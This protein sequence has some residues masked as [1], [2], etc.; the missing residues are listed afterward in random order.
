MSCFVHSKAHRVR[1]SAPHHDGANRSKLRIGAGRHAQ[2]FAISTN[3]STV[4][5]KI[6]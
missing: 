1:A 6:G 2:W 4:S 5:V 3:F